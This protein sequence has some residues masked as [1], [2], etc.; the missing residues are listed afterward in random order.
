MPAKL[1]IYREITK[2]W[3]TRFSVF[4]K[5]EYSF[6]MKLLNLYEIHSLSF[7]KICFQRDM[8]AI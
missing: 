8:E 3:N 2:K 4:F 6:K 1:M 5:S 7:Y